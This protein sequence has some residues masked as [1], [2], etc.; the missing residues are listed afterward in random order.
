MRKGFTILEL[1][2]S[3]SI[4]F[5]LISF[6]FLPQLKIQENVVKLEKKIGR[7]SSLFDIKGLLGSKEG[8]LSVSAQ[9][10][11]N[12]DLCPCIIG[13]NSVNATGDII[14][15]KNICEADKNF[16]F[17]FYKPGGG[18]LLKLTGKSNS[19][20]YYNENGELC[21]LPNPET[22]CDYKLQTSFV[23]KCIGDLPQCDHANYVIA[24]LKL[25]STIKNKLISDESTSFMYFPHVN[26]PPSI[27]SAFNNLNLILGENKTIEAVADS[28]NVD[29]DQNFIYEK[30]SSDNSAVAEIKCYKFENK[31][32]AIIVKAKAV[33]SAKIIVQINDN[34]EANNLSPVYSFDIVVTP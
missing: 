4:F 16:D 17:A 7:N 5:I 28:G 18:P 2:V 6:V 32:S 3:L 13:G 23:A 34:Q 20:V 11:E 30:C 19:A 21:N 25:A 22:S 8:S 15:S 31:K 29:E 10:T 12:D 27:S 33:G 1:I 14:C 24:S 26:Y 9:L